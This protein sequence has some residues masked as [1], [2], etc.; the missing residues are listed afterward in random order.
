M[1]WKRPRSDLGQPDIV[2]GADLLYDVRK[3]LVSYTALL[4]VHLA[5]LATAPLVIAFHSA[6]IPHLSIVE[7]G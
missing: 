6:C 1:D 4:P 3:S 2:L 7:L 5:F